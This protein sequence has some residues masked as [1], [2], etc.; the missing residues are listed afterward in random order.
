MA[1]DLLTYVKS[2]FLVI[3]GIG[4][5]CPY[6]AKCLILVG[7]WDLESRNEVVV[8]GIILLCVMS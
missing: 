7:L 8:I 2:W 5:K 6:E 3:V 1:L 4:Y